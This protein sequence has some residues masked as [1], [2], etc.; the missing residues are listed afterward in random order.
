MTERAI[1]IDSGCGP[2]KDLI[3]K[4]KLEFIGIKILMDRF[5]KLGVEP[6]IIIEGRVWPTVACHS[7]PE[8]FAIGV[9]GEQSPIE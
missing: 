7:G 1:M 9:Y 5:E 3:E 4:F 2:T 8:G 6:D